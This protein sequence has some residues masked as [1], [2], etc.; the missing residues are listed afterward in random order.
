VEVECSSNPRSRRPEIECHKP[1]PGTQNTVHFVKNTLEHLRIGQVVKHR[2]R[3]YDVERLAWEGNHL[4]VSSDEVSVVLRAFELSFRLTNQT[5]RRLEANHEALLIGSPRRHV[6]QTARATA[7]VQES[8]ARTDL[9]GV[10]HLAK[11]FA[12]PAQHEEALNRIEGAPE[13]AKDLASCSAGLRKAIRQAHG[14]Q[15]MR[16]VSSSRPTARG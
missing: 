4:G 16:R 10:E 5:I 6:K 11:E 12:A 7:N 14:T 9:R 13:P 1:P 3:S 15:S 2:S 8:L